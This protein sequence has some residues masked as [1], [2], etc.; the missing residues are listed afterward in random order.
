MRER[1]RD[2]GMPGKRIASKG[3]KTVLLARKVMHHFYYKF[4]MLKNYKRDMNEKL[5]VCRKMPAQMYRVIRKRGPT[6][7][8][9]MKRDILW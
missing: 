5:K 3:M 2:A 1:I 7:R 8:Y 6:I 9:R 4:R